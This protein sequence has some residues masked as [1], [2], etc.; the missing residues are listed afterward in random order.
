[1][2]PATIF[3]TW[4]LGLVASVLDQCAGLAKRA[5]NP[6]AEYAIEVAIYAASHF[7]VNL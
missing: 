7:M 4:I 5:E 6:G 2:E 3:D 1:L